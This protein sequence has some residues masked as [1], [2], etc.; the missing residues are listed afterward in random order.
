MYDWKLPSAQLKLYLV[1]NSCMMT[2]Q[3]YLRIFLQHTGCTLLN[4]KCQHTAQLHILY[5]YHWK[6][7]PVQLKLYLV[8]NSG[9]M[10]NQ[11]Y[12]RISLPHSFYMMISSYDP[13]IS[14]Q[15]SN[16]TP[17]RGKA[18]YSLYHFPNPKAIHNCQRHHHLPLMD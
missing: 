3:L 1:D 11:L 5:M 8:D 4:L 9:M 13:D 12:L 16:N 2:N 14:Q 6:L 15:H 18:I 10:T 17:Q 7:L